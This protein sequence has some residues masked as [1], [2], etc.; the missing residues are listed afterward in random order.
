V[1]GLYQRFLHR[2]GSTAEV[3][4]W[5]HSLQAGISFDQVLVNFLASAEYAK[6][7]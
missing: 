6:N 1:Q 7:L 3:D 5:V 2:N 4:L